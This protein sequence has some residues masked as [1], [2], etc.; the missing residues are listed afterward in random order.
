MLNAPANPVSLRRRVLGASSWSLAGY[1]LSYAIRLGSS[2]LLTRLLV[3]QMFGV[4]AI[5]L[6]V[7]TALV[8]FSDFGLTQNVVQSKRGG[9]PDYL[10][11]AWTVR[12]IRGLLLWLLALCVAALILVANRLGLVPHTSVYADPYIPSVIAVVSF[13][14]IIEGL[15]STKN[16]EASRNLALGRLTQI[17]IIG[18]IAGLICII[19]W[20]LIDRSIWALVAGS[21]FSTAVVT[22]LSHLW[23][24]GVSNRWHWDH[25]AFQE[26]FHFGK[27]IFLS[28]ILGFFANNSDRLLL[29]GFVD[30]SML[31]IYSIAFALFSSIPQ[32]MHVIFSNVAFPAFS[33]VARD[34]PR[35][36]KR[37]LYQFHTLTASFTYLCAGGL[38]V[39]GSH[40]IS[41]LY[42]RRYAQAGWMLELL[43]VAL[44][45]I[46]FGLAQYCL[47]ARGLA[48]VFT[49]VIAV[50]VGV[51][52]VLIPLGF[53][54]FGFTG[55]LWGIVASQLSSAPVV[56]Y[57]QVKHHL[58]DLPKELM[59]LPLLLAGMILG[60]GFNLAIG[61]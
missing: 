57:Y 11:T 33:E 55:A 10:N 13:S 51:T 36:L 48:R 43:A 32:I 16:A 46:P 56:I 41:L 4:M 50:R 19:S 23:L 52:F 49:T 9:D 37:T 17:Q 2:L 40:L 21:I 38:F 20:V 59:L 12:I 27:W 58:L 15:T 18:Q 28:S 53:H 31:G 47:L 39:S 5:A 14:A 25:S 26:I 1:A 3:P 24:P 54:F 42:D 29:G 45:N 60:K 35:D 6:L 61:H 7:M 22:L 8:M 34:R 44:L 30:S